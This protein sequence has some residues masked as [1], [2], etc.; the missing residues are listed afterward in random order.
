MSREADMP[1]SART[2]LPLSVDI[3][4]DWDQLQVHEAAWRTLLER[5]HPL[6]SP[7]VV[8]DRYR[9]TTRAFGEAVKPFAIVVSQHGEPRGMALGRM[10][11]RPIRCRVGYASVSFPS[12]RTL[13][14]MH[15]GVI[16]GD[17]SVAAS[18]ADTLA[19]LRSGDG[20][21]LVNLN[22]L[23]L[24]HPVHAHLRAVIPVNRIASHAPEPHFVV[25]IIPGDFDGT[26]RAVLS[27][28][29]RHEVRRE[30]RR[31]R[32][33]F[34]GD[35]EL[36]RHEEP[37]DIDTLLEAACA[38]AGTTYKHA[39]GIGIDSSSRWRAILHSAASAGQL[40]AWLLVACGEPIAFAIGTRVGEQF[41]LEDFGYAP[42]HAK[43]SPGKNILFRIIEQLSLDDCTCLDFGFGDAQYK[44]VFGE[45]CREEATVR[46][47]GRSLR[48]R[49]LRMVDRAASSAQEMAQLL[50]PEQAGV[51]RLKKAWRR[52]LAS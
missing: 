22:R 10:Q 46:L 24:Q 7:N 49:A 42:E 45:V 26:L 15:G 12:V 27:T 2:E 28:K 8:P 33:Q 38:I 6:L 4:R 30:H 29:R 40:R 41:F 37:E 44:R 25:P 52:R 48:A 34:D 5:Q 18:I 50:L 35:V 32:D 31:L 13:D 20:V 3:V 36:V 43:W 17:D 23:P 51:A 9:E 1:S 14:I 21:D 11:T 47:F 19:H 39:L 16:V